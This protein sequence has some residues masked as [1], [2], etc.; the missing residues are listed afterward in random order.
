[1]VTAVPGDKLRLIDLL[2]HTGAGMYENKRERRARNSRSRVAEKSQEA[3]PLAGY[4]ALPDLSNGTVGTIISPA[5][6]NPGHP[7]C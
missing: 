1:M 7:C 4:R 5:V 3:V 6:R 2:T